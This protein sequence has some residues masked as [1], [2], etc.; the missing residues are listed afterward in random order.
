MAVLHRTGRSIGRISANRPDFFEYNAAWLKTGRE[1]SPLHLP[2][3]LE[4]LP[5]SHDQSAFENLRAFLDHLPGLLGR[6]RLAAI[7]TVPMPVNMT[8][9]F[10]E[11]VALPLFTLMVTGRPDGEAGATTTN[12]AFS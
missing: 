9:L 8:V 7:I 11:I 4:T 12:G 10:A 1:L 2:H 3:S 5:S 6:P